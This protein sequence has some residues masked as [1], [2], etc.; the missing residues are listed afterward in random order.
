MRTNLNNQ[1]F[2]SKVCH[3]GLKLRYNLFCSSAAPVYDAFA[4]FYGRRGSKLQPAGDGQGSL[5]FYSENNGW[6]VVDLGSG[7]EWKV[8]REAQL[9]VSRTVSCAGFLVFVYDGDYW[10]YEFFDR[11]EV[12]DHFVQ[13]ATGEPIGFPGEDCRGNPSVVAERLPFL[14]AEDIA[15][16]LV[17]MHDWVIPEGMDVP[18]R[19]ADEF[20]RF[21][22][23]AVLDF[24]ECLASPPKFVIIMCG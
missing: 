10:G 24:C 1:Q 23:C 7:W 13:E 8:R 14:R 6:T 15:P 21:D 5:N 17:Q 12:L 4:S 19:P 3:L 18:A 2:V 16:Y 22:E 9:F 11:G 20:R